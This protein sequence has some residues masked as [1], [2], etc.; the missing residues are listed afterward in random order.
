[1]S[2][3]TWQG[4]RGKVDGSST[5]HGSSKG[6]C[7]HRVFLFLSQWQVIWTMEVLSCRISYSRFILSLPGHMESPHSNMAISGETFYL[8]SWFQGCCNWFKM[9]GNKRLPH[10]GAPETC[11]EKTSRLSLHRVPWQCDNIFLIQV[12]L[13]IRDFVRNSVAI[14]LARLSTSLETSIRGTRVLH[15]CY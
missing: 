11:P 5:S 8:Y 9:R 1:M 6:R 10:W 12:P 7:A 15:I 3:Q 14:P 13:F 2:C 4:G